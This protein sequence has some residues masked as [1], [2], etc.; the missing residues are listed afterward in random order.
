MLKGTLEGKFTDYLPHNN[1]ARIPIKRDEMPI[2]IRLSN[3]NQGT[4]CQPEEH[5]KH[6]RHPAFG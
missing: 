4:P 1:G 6:R 3:T 2:F 5:Q